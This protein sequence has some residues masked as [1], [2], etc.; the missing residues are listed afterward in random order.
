[1]SNPRRVGKVGQRGERRCEAPNVLVFDR[2][3]LTGA[4]YP[5]KEG[6]TGIVESIDKVETGAKKGY[7]KRQSLPKASPVDS[8]PQHVSAWLRQT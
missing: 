8:P 1:M 6:C 5:S 3:S 4:F 2:Q 7:W